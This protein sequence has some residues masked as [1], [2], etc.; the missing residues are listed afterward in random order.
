[1]TFAEFSDPE[2]ERD[3]IPVS[4]A[5]RPAPLP[6]PMLDHDRPASTRIPDAERE[7]GLAN[8]ARFRAWII[9]RNEARARGEQPPEAP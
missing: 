3:A 5:P 8:A 7:L 6:V 9:E 4:P 2:F 1:M